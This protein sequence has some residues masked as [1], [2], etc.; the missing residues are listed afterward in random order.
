[1]F[2]YPGNDVVILI[3]KLLLENGFYLLNEDGDF[4]LKEN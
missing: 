2:N 4:M 3:Y 1:M